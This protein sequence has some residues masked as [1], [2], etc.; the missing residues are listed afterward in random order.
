MPSAWEEHSRFVGDTG[1]NRS[2]SLCS[3]LDKEVLAGGAG[4]GKESA[5]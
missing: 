5:S 4:D 3:R 1:I 2:N